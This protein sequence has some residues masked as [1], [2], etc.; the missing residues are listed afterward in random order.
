MN[1]NKAVRSFVGTFESARAASFAPANLLASAAL[2]HLRGD[3]KKT[4]V[5]TQISDIFGVINRQRPAAPTYL[6]FV[7]I[8]MTCHL[9]DMIPAMCFRVERSFTNISGIFQI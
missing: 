6:L 7:M 5:F 3:S 2:A 4:T 9:M 1:Q 8:V